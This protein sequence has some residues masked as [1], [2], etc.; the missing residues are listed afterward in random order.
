M[1]ADNKT[2]IATMQ[3]VVK[4]LQTIKDAVDVLNKALATKI[5]ADI[6]ANT[7][8]D[9]DETTYETSLQEYIDDFAL[10]SNQLVSGDDVA[11]V[12]KISQ[13]ILYEQ[14][15]V[16]DLIKNPSYGCEAELKNQTNSDIFKDHLSDWNDFRAP[17]PQPHLYDYDKKMDD[18]GETLTEY[19]KTTK[20]QDYGFLM[21]VG[22]G[23]SV[24]S[25]SCSGVIDDQQNSGSCSGNASIWENVL[26]IY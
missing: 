11:S 9:S 8:T 21:S 17:Y 6:A 5:A 26:G 16:M 4:K 23:N 2:E 1:I 18:T 22:F 13:Q 3:G 25:T 7:K 24:G 20:Q 12:D 14:T 10:I 19:L 15:H